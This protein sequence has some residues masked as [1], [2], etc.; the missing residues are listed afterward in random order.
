M[1]Y[2]L[3]SHRIP[4]RTHEEIKSRM[5]E[6]PVS[7]E[8]DLK[9][10]MF[11]IETCWESIQFPWSNQFRYNMHLWPII[12][13]MA[14]VYGWKPVYPIEKYFLNDG[15]IVNDD[16]AKSLAIALD[17]AIPDIPDEIIE[18]DDQVFYEIKDEQDE[19]EIIKGLFDESLL[20]K[21]KKNYA[22]SLSGEYCKD[23]LKRFI[24]F[25]RHGEFS[26]E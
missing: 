6:T 15:L 13:R 18:H 14:T 21:S 20:E 11:S 16:E 12:L 23:K 17:K 19:K 22:I 25:C 5:N 1:G 26:I 9:D 24:E 4:E 7:G 2:D 8:G 10:V 3:Y